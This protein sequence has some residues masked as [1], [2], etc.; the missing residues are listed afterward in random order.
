M[1]KQIV[2]LNLSSFNSSVVFSS[3][4]VLGCTLV[5]LT[6]DMDVPQHGEAASWYEQAIE[7]SKL[8]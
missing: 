4:K 2:S 8:L 5:V 7:M 6:T 3:A 1:C